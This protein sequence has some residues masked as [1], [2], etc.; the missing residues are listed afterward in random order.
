MIK[1]RRLIKSFIYAFRGLVKTFREEQNFKIQVAI[2]ALVVGAGLFLKISRLEW[3]IIILSIA[4]VVLMEIANSAVERI[5]DVLKPRIDSYV[6]EIKDVTAA[7]VM[8]AS[9][10]AAI[11]GVI[12]FYPHLVKYFFVL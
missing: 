3:C 4:S 5:T 9:L 8:L 7:A 1:F 10:V 2:G 12:I 6:K 11:I